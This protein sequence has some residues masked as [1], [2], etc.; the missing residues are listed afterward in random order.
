MWCLW[1]NKTKR[2]AAFVPNPTDMGL[3]RIYNWPEDYVCFPCSLKIQKDLEKAQR[4]IREETVNNF[5]EDAEKRGL[6][7]ID[8]AQ[9]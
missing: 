8:F 3:K 6:T 2:K 9:G 1:C 4:I 5:S 7:I